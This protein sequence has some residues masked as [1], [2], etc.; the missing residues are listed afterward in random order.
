MDD[1][2]LELF[3][4]TSTICFK[5]EQ[6]RFSAI[7][8]NFIHYTFEHASFFVLHYFAMGL[9]IEKFNTDKDLRETK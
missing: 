5:F 1:F 2:V 6:N 9:P 3:G 7:A 8:Y 4:L